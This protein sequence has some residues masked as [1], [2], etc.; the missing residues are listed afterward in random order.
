M[1]QVCSDAKCYALSMP[2]CKKWGKRRGLPTKNFLP[3]SAQGL[4]ALCLAGVK[5]VKAIR[6]RGGCAA[7]VALASQ[8]NG[9]YDN[10]PLG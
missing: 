3:L 9:L 10:S 7:A 8:F 5:A 1:L 2:C 4:P 6:L